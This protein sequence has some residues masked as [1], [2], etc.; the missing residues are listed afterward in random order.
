MRNYSGADWG[1][2]H[3]VSRC[4]RRSFDMPSISEAEYIE[5]ADFTGPE[6]HVGKRGK[7]A[8]NEPKALTKL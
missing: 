4:V 5:L 3:R 8:E 1:T 7:I 6:L 2:F